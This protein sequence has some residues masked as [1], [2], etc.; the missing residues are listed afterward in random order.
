MQSKKTSKY[1][2]IAAIVATWKPRAKAQK[3]HLKDLAKEG[4]ITPQ[5]LTKI[6]AGKINNPRLKTVNNVEMFLRQKEGGDHA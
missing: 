1:P 2:F 6:I 5:H 3:I 4:R